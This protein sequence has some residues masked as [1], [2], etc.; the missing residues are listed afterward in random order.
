VEHHGDVR[1]DMGLDPA[2]GKNI[3]HIGKQIRKGV[4]TLKK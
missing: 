3:E 4:K 2:A 1:I